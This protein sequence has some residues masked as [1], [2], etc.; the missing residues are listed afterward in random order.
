VGVP[1]VSSVVSSVLASRLRLV[2]ASCLVF[3]ALGAVL[4][5]ACLGPDPFA[6]HLVA[7]GGA[8]GQR[9]DGDNDGGAGTTGDAGTTGFVGTA[10][11]LGVDGGADTMPLKTPCTTCMV[12]VSYTCRTDQPDGGQSPERSFIVDVTNASSITIP[13]SSLTLRYWYTIPA[14]AQ[15]D[16]ALDCDTAKIGCT[17]VVTSANGAPNFV[18]VLP[19]KMNANEYVEIAFTLGALSLD[20]ALDT[21]EIQ[22][23]VHNKSKTE[24]DQSHDYSIDCAMKGN[25]VDNPHIT[26]YVDDVLVWGVEPT[27]PPTP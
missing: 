27:M 22:L 19:P 14:G 17:N 2:T 18:P 16:Q 25:A 26:A 12:E 21:G 3:V 1:V 9:S 7:A 20:P 13:L 15:A 11:V 8:A 4:G 24:V 23:R 10:G 5:G 6:R